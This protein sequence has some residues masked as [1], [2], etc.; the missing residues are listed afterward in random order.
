MTQDIYYR[1]TETSAASGRE[2][3][4]T[5]KHDRYI[6]IAHDIAA[7]SGAYGYRT[8]DRDALEILFG[9]DEVP[10]QLNTDL[11]ESGGTLMEINGEYY[12]PSDAPSELEWA[13]DV[14]GHDR[15]VF[16]RALI[17]EDEYY[18]D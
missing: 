14:H 16:S 1:I 2:S 4:W 12:K 7:R 17:T 15:R 8:V 13:D 9:A 6:S 10:G 5:I 11:I 18:Q 3:T